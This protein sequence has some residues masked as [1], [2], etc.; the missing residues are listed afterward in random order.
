MPYDAS[1]AETAKIKNFKQEEAREIRPRGNGASHS[2]GADK[3]DREVNW[4]WLLHRNMTSLATSSRISRRHSKFQF[5]CKLD[6]AI[7]E[8]FVAEYFSYVAFL[9]SH[10]R[11]KPQTKFG[12]IVLSATL[13]LLKPHRLVPSI[14]HSVIEHESKH[15]AQYSAPKD[16]TLCN[17]D[18]A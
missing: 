6:P 5:A 12:I 16:L 18:N 4:S 2:I 14:K 1:G 9:W 7:H 15:T 10:R 8:G 13:G 3:L 17:E 11:N